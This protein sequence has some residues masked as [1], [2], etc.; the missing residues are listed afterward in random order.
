MI[1]RLI[2]LGGLLVLG[3][4]AATAADEPAPGIIRMSPYE[5]SASGANFQHWVKFQSPHF[6]LY[7]DANAEDAARIVGEFEKLHLAAIDYLRR[8]AFQRARTI[9][10]LPTSRSDWRKIE[11]A[12]AVEW[13]VAVAQPASRLGGFIVVQYDWQGI[14]RDLDTVYAAV[15]KSTLQAMK[16]EAPLWFGTGI[17]RFFETVKFE[18]DS[19]V[20]GKM[21][22]RAR[23]LWM[24]GWL[25]WPDFFK[26]T[27]SSPEFTKSSEIG[28]FT[29]Q[30]AAFMHFMLTKSDPAWRERMMRWS[31][32]LHAGREPTEASFKEIFGEGWEAWQATMKAHVRDRSDTTTSIVLTA[33]QL[34]FPRTKMDLPVREMRELFVL[35]QIL[36]QKG[37]ACEAALDTLLARGLQSEPLRE[38]L[39]EACIKWKRRE[40][41]TAQLQRLIAGGSTNPAVYFTAADNLFRTVASAITLQVRLG[42]KAV[43]IGE[44]CRKA[45]AIE[46]RHPD[47]NNLLAWSEAL[48]PEMRAENVAAIQAI[49]QA[50]NGIAP[51][52]EVASALAVARWRSGDP[53][54]ARTLAMMLRDSPY[55]NKRGRDLAI[56]LLA[57]LGASP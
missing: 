29:G 40:A 8:P 54:G 15:G 1:L 48:G 36:N 41:A 30:S 2:F 7:T 12:A 26:A 20:L 25:P 38:L 37:P 34:S 43:E 3:R 11:S 18:E 19:V 53:S 50:M 47:A 52:Q 22:V 33:E 49:L 16:L 32:Q 39:L 21:S 44:L 6:T 42:E 5:V 55:T 35:T 23:S 4:A 31:A 45:L 17:G 28:K 24:R 46:P 14:L 56:A 27:T 9:V 10:V 13:N 57:E 51:M